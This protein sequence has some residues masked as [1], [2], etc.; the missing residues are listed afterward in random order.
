MKKLIVETYGELRCFLV[1]WSTQSLSTLGSSMTSFAV[2]IWAFGQNGSALQTA[3][4]MVCSY[5]PYVL[6]SIFAGAL[7]DRWDKKRTMLICDSVAAL[8]TL[9][10]L[11][12]LTS[13]R[14]AV[15]HL[16]GINILNGLMNTVQQPASEVAVSLLCPLRHYQRASGLRS[17]SNS[18]V[19]LLTPILSTA[20]LAFAGLKAVIFFDLATFCIAFLSLLLFV[21][22][23][24][25]KAERA[26]NQKV[27]LSVKL[28]LRFLRDNR[29]IF[30]LILFLAIINFTASIYNAA[31]PAMLLSRA[32]GGELA[33][34]AVNAAT[35]LAAML[36]GV[37]ATLLPAPRSRTRVICNCLLFSMSTE[38]F[39]LAFGR[40]VPVWCAGAVLGWLFIPLMNANME[41]LLRVKIPLEMQGRVYSA[42]NALQFFTIPLGYL[43]GGA[44]V[45]LVFEPFMATRHGSIFA[46]L[47]GSGKGTG[48][49]LL[50]FVIGV[51]GALSCLPFR[52][53]R[54][55]RSLDENAGRK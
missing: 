45:D 25:A 27:F 41:A 14:L 31:L 48:A 8:C 11:G 9:A 42:R 10:V 33:L 13:G 46:A 19:T 6:L 12:L 32:N 40:S 39:F 15:W 22:I 3:L 30:H 51:C 55:I 23:P 53:D 37:L 49:A 36:G 5:A 18:V 35:G 1:L 17:L 54:H 43:C 20:L 34:G 26:E 47:F 28:G 50:F 2:V 38:N 4:L 7:S 24:A 16:Y 44:L 52:F 21:R 29:G